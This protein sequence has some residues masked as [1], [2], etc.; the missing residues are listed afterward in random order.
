MSSGAI[1]LEKEFPDA[2][3]AGLYIEIA[4]DAVVLA[5]FQYQILGRVWPEHKTNTA[6]GV[7]IRSDRQ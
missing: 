4:F 1:E 3:P 2:Y 6:R 5:F 7:E